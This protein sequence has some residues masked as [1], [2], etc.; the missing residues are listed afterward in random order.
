[1]MNSQYIIED[2]GR[3]LRTAI[4]ILDDK[5]KEIAE[6]KTWK[7]D[8]TKLIHDLDETLEWYGD[9]HPM[10]KLVQFIWPRRG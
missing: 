4:E 5:K 10:E 8:V 6:L 9:D 7:N 3:K 2:L 1:M